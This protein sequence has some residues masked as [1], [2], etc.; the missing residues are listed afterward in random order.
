MVFPFSFFSVSE[1][2]NN[3]KDELSKTS[4]DLSVHIEDTV[5]EPSSAAVVYSSSSTRLNQKSK[6]RLA[7]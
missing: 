3:I 6:T 5:R 2:D 7:S 1:S 4:A